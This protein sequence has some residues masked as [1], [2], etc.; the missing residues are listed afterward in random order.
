MCW[1]LASYSMF[2]R[3]GEQWNVVEQCNKPGSLMCVLFWYTSGV[4]LCRNALQVPA[5]TRDLLVSDPPE[6][7]AAAQPHGDG[8]SHP[9]GD[10]VQPM[11]ASLHAEGDDDGA[12]A[13]AAEAAASDLA[14]GLRSKAGLGS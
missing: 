8:D 1:R 11:D 2:S 12:A 6:G 10:A 5:Y 4:P 7:S 13:A 9:H 3:V 14:D